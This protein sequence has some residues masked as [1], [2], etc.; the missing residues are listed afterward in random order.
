MARRWFYRALTADW[1]PNIAAGVFVLSRVK[2]LMTDQA[3]SPH[4]RRERFLRRSMDAEA[5]A[6]KMRDAI[7]RRTWMEL[8]SR[9]A[10][11]A[12]KIPPR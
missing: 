10:V 4:Q 6:L 11:L 2:S 1:E 12:K 3:E 9:Y 5:N 8:A 7:E